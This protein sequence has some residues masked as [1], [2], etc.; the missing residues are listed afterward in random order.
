MSPTNSATAAQDS[1]EEKTVSR[2]VALPPKLWKKVNDKVASEFGDNRSAYFRQLVE[3]D[4]GDAG[5]ATGTG[6]LIQLIRDYHP[7]LEREAL[8]VIG[9]EIIAGVPSFSQEKFV[10]RLL[11]TAV[12]LLQVQAQGEAGILREESAIE[13]QLRRDRELQSALDAITDRMVGV[14]LLHVA[15]DIGGETDPRGAAEQVQK[16]PS[17]LARRQ[18]SQHPGEHAKQG[19]A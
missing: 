11:E 2:S 3:T 4:L 1:S 5:A 6:P 7:S 13:T 18:Q 10:A 8:R 15:E 16:Q 14:K 17:A 9:A 12:H 19:G